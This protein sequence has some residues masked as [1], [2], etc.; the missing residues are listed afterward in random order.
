[1]YVRI[2]LQTFIGATYRYPHDVTLCILCALD[3]DTT[4]QHSDRAEQRQD[5]EEQLRPSRSFDPGLDLR[6]HWLCIRPPIR[7]NQIAIRMLIDIH[8][9]ALLLLPRWGLGCARC[10]SD[11]FGVELVRY[12]HERVPRGSVVEVGLPAAHVDE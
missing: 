5:S 11:C 3:E 2:G 10:H 8:Q 9:G 12:V 4:E 7:H 1:M 6:V